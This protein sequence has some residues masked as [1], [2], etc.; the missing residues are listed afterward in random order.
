MSARPAMTEPEAVEPTLA[1]V[2]CTMTRSGS[3]LLCD[4]LSATRRAGKPE[5]YFDIHENNRNHWRRELKI[6]DDSHYV[7]Q[8]VRAATTP[9][10]VFGLKLHWYQLPEM[11][12]M[13]GEPVAGIDLD[14]VLSSRFPTRKYLWL[15]RRNKVAQAISN[16]RAL[17]SQV[18]RI[19]HGVPEKKPKIAD[20]GF[21]AAAIEHQVAVVEHFDRQWQ[22]WFQ[23]SRR[24]ALVLYYEDFSQ[25]YERTVRGVCDYLGVGGPDLTIPEP[26]LER[27][28]D[29]MSAEWEDRYRKLKGLPSEAEAQAVLRTA[30]LLTAPPQRAA[31]SARADPAAP[32]RVTAY[33]LG[34]GQNVPLVPAAKDRAWMDATPQRFANRCLP[35]LIANQHGWMMLAPY[36]IEAMWDG[37]VDIS[38]VVVREPEGTTSHYALSHFGSGILTF[39]ANYLFRTPPGVNLHVRGPAN[40]PKD[41]IFALE[42]VVETDWTEATFTMNWKFTRPNHTVVFEAGEPFAMFSPVRRGDLEAYKPIMLPLAANPT[43]EAGYKAWSASRSAF[44]RDLKVPDSEA[45]KA[46]WQRHYTRGETVSRER[47][48]S[49]QTK[50]AVSEFVD[51]RKS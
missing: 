14:R 10:G 17:K 2:V 12:K 20:L 27:Q 30:R 11:M 23:L 21:D 5:E 37:G 3:S 32:P 19:G 24:Q 13:F 38:S 4:A 16:Y 43:L 46:G 1:Y 22:T 51:R 48:Q 8:V 34:T 42:G 26:R 29:D 31:D 7:D 18:W 9:N 33:D 36:R 49:H 28:S 39:T 44:N 40:L 35:L 45:V 25:T 15:R 50:L 6:T 47:A 41:G